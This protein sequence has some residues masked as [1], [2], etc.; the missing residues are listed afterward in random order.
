MLAQ[1]RKD[2]VLGDPQ[3]RR[4]KFTIVEVGYAPGRPSQRHAVALFK[5]E[6]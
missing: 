5:M 4:R 1:Q 6:S 2:R 3:T